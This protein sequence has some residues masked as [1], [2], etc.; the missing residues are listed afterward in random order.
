MKRKLLNIN[1]ELWIISASFPPQNPSCFVIKPSG[2]LPFPPWPCSRYVTRLREA[3]EE[4]E[5]KTGGAKILPSSPRKTNMA[6]WQWNIYHGN[7]EDA[8]LFGN[9]N[10]MIPA[11]H[12]LWGW[13]TD[14]APGTPST[15]A[16]PGLGVEGRNGRTPTSWGSLLGSDKKMAIQRA[17]CRG[18][19]CSTI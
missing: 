18:I 12:D 2:R 14:S 3:V 10:I 5:R 15:I 9:G 11:L 4:T 17:Y 1:C 6:G 8:F 7:D 13:N 16:G 19:C